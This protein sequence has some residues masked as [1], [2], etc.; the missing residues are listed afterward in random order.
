MRRLIAFTFIATLASSL[1]AQP[2]M[3]NAEEGEWRYVSNLSMSE[4]IFA[5]G[6]LSLRCEK[7]RGLV[8]L[9]VNPAMGMTL[10]LMTDQGR[11]S[12]GNGQQLPARLTA[13][14]NLA[15][16]RGKFAIEDNVSGQNRI[17]P[18]DSAVARSI[19]DCR[20]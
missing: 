11:V 17:F 13:L 19:E 12:I 16:A 18:W 14:D 9:T 10:N 20:I 2:V 5:D 6:A 7:A 8:S 3:G 1:S 15:F 4:A